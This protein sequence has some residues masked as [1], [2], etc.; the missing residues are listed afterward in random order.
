MPLQ[1]ALLDFVGDAQQVD[2]RGVVSHLSNERLLD[3]VDIAHTLDVLER[4]GTE[5][6]ML[7]LLAFLYAARVDL[8]KER[9]TQ[10]QSSGGDAVV[11]EE[12]DASPFWL[13]MLVQGIE[14]YSGQG[15][16]HTVLQS[17]M[18]A[19]TWTAAY[20]EYCWTGCQ[21]FNH[22]VLQSVVTADTWTAA[23]GEYCWTG[24][25]GFN[26]TVLQS[27]MTADTWTAAYGE[28]CWTGCQGFNHTVLQ[29]VMTADTWTAAYLSLIH[30]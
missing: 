14:E 18:T 21:G 28:Y 24:C 3:P 4:D 8:L 6:A 13:Q 5:A 15:F 11:E 20:G 12:G 30:I 26:H 23:Y 10:R 19:D 29:S 16:N 25:R 1:R 7:L 17:V 9:F 22:T 27:V 2:V